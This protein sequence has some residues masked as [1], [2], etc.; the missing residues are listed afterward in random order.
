[1]TGYSGDSGAAISATLFVPQRLA[2]DSAG[3]LYVADQS[4][5]R[6]RVISRSTGT[7]T[8]VAGTGAVGSNGDGGPATSAQL[9][10]PQGVAVDASGNVYI[11]DVWNFKVRL[12]TKATGIITT[13][14]GTGTQG[15]SADGTPAT[16]A[17][18]GRS[19]AVAVDSSGNVYIADVDNRKVYVVTRSTGMMTTFAGTGSTGVIGDGGLAT[20]AF[21]SN[22]DALAVDASDNV[23][24]G[25][26][27]RVRLVTRSSGIITTIA[28]TGARGSG[29]DGGPATSATF[30]GLS[31]V[32]VDASGNVYVADF[33]NH[34]VRLV[35]RSTGK[36]TAF[37]GQAGL[38]GS[39]GDGGAA[40]SAL[41]VSPVGVAVDAYG[42]VFISDFATNRIREVFAPAATSSPV[43]AICA[44]SFHHSTFSAQP[45]P[46]SR[47]A[48]G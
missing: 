40:T 35:T 15:S 34:N 10:Y 42:N 24:I 27:T 1:M 2:V 46:L 43:R 3:N 26:G 38:P 28:G 36:V 17:Q 13:Y 48:R 11:A 32:A 20:V 33:D 22:P 7:I 9:N 37:A 12:V 16:S 23:Y 44:F 45:L 31:G 29:G 30:S 4:N 5:N 41:L 39:T 18:L 47:N 25:D 19:R 8:T 6:V 14:A 21:V